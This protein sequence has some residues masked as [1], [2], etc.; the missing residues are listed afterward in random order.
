MKIHIDP[1]IAGRIKAAWANL[2]SA[3]Q[4]RVAPMLARAS[5][6]RKWSRP[7]DKRHPCPPT[8]RARHY[9]SPPR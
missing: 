4:S 2:S 6:L 3:Q 8:C 7:Q 1:V 9:S 5:H